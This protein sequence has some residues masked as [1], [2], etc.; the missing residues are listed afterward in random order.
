MKDNKFTFFESYHK[1]LSRVSDEQ[2]GRLVRALSNYAFYDEEPTFNE[3][4]D[5]IAWEL[6]KP[7]IDNGREISKIRSECGALGGANGKGVS[8]NIGNKF[9]AK[10]ESIAKNSKTIAKAFAANE[11][12]IA[13]DSQNNSGKDMERNEKEM[14][15]EREQDAPTP[16]QLE[17]VVFYFD[18]HDKNKVSDP[19]KFFSY[20]ESMGWMKNGQP[21]INWKS[22]A[23]LWINED[24]KKTAG[25][26]RPQPFV[27]SI[28]TKEEMA[29]KEALR[30]S[31]EHERFKGTIELVKNDN[32]SFASIA[33]K[34]ALDN[35]TLDK[36]PDLK[37]QAEALFK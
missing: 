10:S 22:R 21:I 30:E 2:Y 20:F 15:W 8:R 17:D 25:K 26:P 16:P 32:S 5:W 14:E 3:D 37:E 6:I 35:G 4:T 9:A 19:N 7:I 24:I 13:T 1:A 36:Y 34:N 29:E 23:D 11:E 18:E 27:L 33:I 12:T 28:P 31:S